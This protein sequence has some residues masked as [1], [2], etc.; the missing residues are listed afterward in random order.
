[1][2]RRG[3]RAGGLRVAALGLALLGLGPVC[4]PV[5]GPGS[6]TDTLTIGAYSVVREAFHE[7]LLPAF[8]SEWKRRT[9]RTVRVGSG[10]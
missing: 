1:M 7:G 9:G 3:W 8:A 6:A 5:R 2:R 4:A 10:A